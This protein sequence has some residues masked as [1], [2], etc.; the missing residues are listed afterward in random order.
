MLW[1]KK[2]IAR[3]FN[4]EKH[5]EVISSGIMLV[6]AKHNIT[7]L[8]TAVDTRADLSDSDFE[9]GINSRAD[10]GVDCGADFGIEPRAD[11]ETAPKA[12]WT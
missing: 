4:Y 10:S 6:R 11:S 5:E 9:C 7:L 1:T 12:E 2:T 3:I 8:R